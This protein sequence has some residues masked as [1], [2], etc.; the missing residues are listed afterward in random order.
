LYFPYLFDKQSEL[1]AIRG[2]AGD[3]GSPQKIVPLVEPV[4][5]VSGLKR[6]YTAFRESGDFAYIIA[7]PHQL[8]LAD[9]TALT[10]W[11]TAAAPLLA[12]KDVFRPVFK[13]RA[14]T[15]KADIVA[16]LAK[17]N[18]RPIGLL[19]TT[20]HL[21]V[22]D[23]QSA[24]GTSDSLVFMTTGAD[25]VALVSALGAGKIVEVN[26]RFPAQRVNA[27]YAGEEWFSRD[28]LDYF[29]VH[30][31]VGFS[32]YTILPA[33]PTKGGGAPGAVAVHLTYK[34]FDS[35]IW[36]Q[37]FVSDET[38]RN[39]GTAGSKL[40]EAIDHLAT[41]NHTHAN[42]FDKSPA[43]NSYLAWAANRANTSLGKN[44]ELEISHHIYVMAKRL[45]I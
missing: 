43:F 4:S 10:A 41:E 2:M 3:F 44:K 30:G 40:L 17:Y 37:H 34:A 29:T 25:R 20:G 32:D 24:L 1:L 39:V 28:H 6:L 7:N 14:G 5:A 42:K 23:I 8:T 33:T 38:D 12:D 22:A 13:E 35:S 45:G 11:E 27:D 26:D 16:F 9:S 36:V 18:G 31:Y 15:T 19:I 21:P